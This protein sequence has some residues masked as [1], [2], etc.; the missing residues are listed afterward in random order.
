[1]TALA[2]AAL[3]AGVADGAR[4]DDASAFGVP[5]DAAG[6]MIA[7]CIIGLGKFGGRELI[8]GLRPRPLRDLRRGRRD[9]RSRA[10][11][12]PRVLRSGRGSALLDPG[13]RDGG[14]R[15]RARWTSGSGPGSQGQRLRLERW[16][17]SAQ[18]Y[19]EWADPWE[20]QT[21]TRARLWS[22]RP[23]ARPRGAAARSDALVYGPDGAAARPQGDA[24][25][26]ASGWRRSSARRRPGALHVKFGRGGLVDVEFITQ[27]IQMI[28]GRR[29]PGDPAPAHGAGAPRDRPRRPPARATTADGARR[30]LPLPPPRLGR[31]APLRRAARRHARAGGAHPGAP[32]E[33]PRLSLAEGV[34]RG[35]PAAHR[36]G[37]RALRPRG[38]GMSARF[39][40]VDGP[41]YLY[42]AYHALPYLSNSKG[43]A[44]PRRPRR[45]HHALEAPPRGEPRVR[46]RW[47]G[48]RRA[49]RFAR[50]SFAV[51]KETRPGMPDD[52]RSQIALRQA[53]SSRRSGCPLLEVPGFEADDVLGTLVRRGCG[54]EP[55]EMVLVTGDKDMLQLVGPRV[56]VLSHGSRAASASVFDEAAVQREVGRGAGADPR[57][58]R[59]HGRHHRQHSRRARRRREDRGQAH[60]P[61]RQRRAALREPHARARAS[62]ARRWPPIASRRS[63]RASWPP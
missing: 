4:R 28:H 58:P 5:R 31:P 41:G 18:Y 22:R 53:A 32:G 23:A 13:R 10:R 50:R 51:Y 49:R 3:A 9:G 40:V 39:F 26:C 56:R 34:P 12:G 37:A 19:R 25:C 35:L 54:R 27:A 24:P 45:V 7:A 29:H 61:V 33:E 17:R 59:A 20:R 11:R 15:G 6:R 2:E 48:I 46:R 55:V 30:A 60:R 38:A 52:L 44:D 21:L 8:D 1:M 43:Q 47:R 57:P 36:L 62:C 14:G 42:R 63:S 16:R